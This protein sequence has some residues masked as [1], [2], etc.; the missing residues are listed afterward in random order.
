V[1]YQASVY[2]HLPGTVLNILVSTYRILRAAAARIW[3][4][5]IRITVGLKPGIRSTFARHVLHYYRREISPAEVYRRR[6]QQR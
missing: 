3:I 2:G 1:H 6:E 5:I 4:G